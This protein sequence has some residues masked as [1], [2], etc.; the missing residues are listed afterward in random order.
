MLQ[1][2]NAD[3]PVAFTSHMNS[4][5]RLEDLAHGSIIDVTV[6]GDVQ[7]ESHLFY[8]CGTTPSGLVVAPKRLGS[9]PDSIPFPRQHIPFSRVMGLKAYSQD[10]AY[11]IGSGYSQER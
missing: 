3:K 1:H 10:S 9:G 8:Y 6:L 11:N 5:F 7:P 4:A 2:H